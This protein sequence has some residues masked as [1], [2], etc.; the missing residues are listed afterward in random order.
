MLQRL[1]VAEPEAFD[2]QSGLVP[3]DFFDRLIIGLRPDP[4]QIWLDLRIGAPESAVA[5]SRE[6]TIAAMLPELGYGARFKPGDLLGSDRR[7][8][9]MVARWAYKHGYAGLAYSCSHR[10]HLDCWA[11]FVGASFSV[12]G[13]PAPISRSDPDV[14]AVAAEFDLTIVFGRQP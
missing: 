12:I 9:Q 4:G 5:L 10:P 8:T 3:D 11:I 1:A 13:R 14:I 2:P 7:L 6:P